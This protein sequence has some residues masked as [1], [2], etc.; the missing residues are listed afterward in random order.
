MH[1][2]G[3]L[4]NALVH[5]SPAWAQG[6][7]LSEPSV[8]I[9]DIGFLPRL[10][11]GVPGAV[12]RLTRRPAGFPWRVHLIA[13]RYGRP[14]PFQIQTK[15]ARI[16]VEASKQSV[17]PFRRV[18]I[19]EKK[20]NRRGALRPCG[21][22]RCGSRG[23]RLGTQALLMGVFPLTDRVPYVVFHTEVVQ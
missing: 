20:A 1:G 11:F 5:R 23:V 19:E 18:F 6:R 12:K 2:L 3:R 8:G 22:E 16:V 10:N 13:G 4:L 21:F 9:D 15:E 17:S 7:H 14:H